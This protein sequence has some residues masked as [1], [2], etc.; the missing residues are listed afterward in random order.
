MIELRMDPVVIFRTFD[1]AEAQLLRSR[2]EGAGMDAQVAHENSAAIL[3][4]G[5]GGVRIVV[6][7]EQA[8]EARA[9][10]EATTG[11]EP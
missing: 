9:L 5:V 4:V 10:L 2:L 11:D 1:L 6:P 8:E 7:A 3:D